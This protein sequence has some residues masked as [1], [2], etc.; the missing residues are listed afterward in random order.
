ML[1]NSL[2]RGGIIK[3]RIHLNRNPPK[4]FDFFELVR[5]IRNIV[6]HAPNF[7]FYYDEEEKGECQIRKK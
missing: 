6:S 5:M 2:Q 7:K 4:D 3:A 1:K